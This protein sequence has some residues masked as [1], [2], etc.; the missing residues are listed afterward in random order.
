MS[1]THH[2]RRPGDD[3]DRPAPKPS[4]KRKRA[5]FSFKRING[6]ESSRLED[7]ATEPANAGRR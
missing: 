5:L 1:R 4:S 6:V 2:V 3:V 7:D